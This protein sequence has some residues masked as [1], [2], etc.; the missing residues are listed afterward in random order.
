MTNNIF[1][2]R[3]GMFWLCLSFL[4]LTASAQTRVVTNLGSP[5]PQIRIARFHTAWFFGGMPVQRLQENRGQLRRLFSAFN[6]DFRELTLELPPGVDAVPEPKPELVALEHQLAWDRVARSL[7]TLDQDVRADDVVFFYL[8][9]HGERNPQGV[10]VFKF[11]GNLDIPRSQLVQRL[12]DIQRE[13]GARL[14]V[15]VTDN[16]SVAANGQIQRLA[17]PGASGI[18]RALYFGH[19]GFVDLSSTDLSGNQAGFVVGGTSIFNEA[20]SRSL[21]LRVF[22]ETR[23]LYEQSALLQQQG[24]LDEAKKALKRAKDRFAELLDNNGDGVVSW[25]DEFERHLRG[26]VAAVYG[27]ALSDL[28][29]REGGRPSQG[30]LD[31]EMQGG[32]TVTFADYGSVRD[33]P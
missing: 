16:C 26:Q 2:H 12:R 8:M 19:D 32:Q 4:P 18:W 22:N 21:N 7:D 31:M 17:L 25:Q 13:R 9:A 3:L 28:Q 27:E 11:A 30:R 20:F 10:P 14:V 33:L 23:N 6:D 1:V 24:R 29:R 5:R 15:L